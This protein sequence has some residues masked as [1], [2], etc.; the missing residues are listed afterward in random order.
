MN[1]KTKLFNIL[2]IIFYLIKKLF[3]IK[4]ISFYR[5]NICFVFFLLNLEKSY[6]IKFVFKFITKKSVQLNYNLFHLNEI[7]FKI[8]TKYNF[9]ANIISIRLLTSS[10]VLK[11]L[12]YTLIV[13]INYYT[14]YIFFKIIVLNTLS[15]ALVLD[16]LFIT[17]I[18]DCSDYFQNKSTLYLYVHFVL[19]IKYYANQMC[20]CYI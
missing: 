3:L 7:N 9:L 12:Y 20:L 4:L 5:V 14:C 15:K 18:F 11:S 13:F 6:T 17:G 19:D 2:N 8:N 1:V 10:A 16:K